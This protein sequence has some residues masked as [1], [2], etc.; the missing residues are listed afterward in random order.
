MKQPKR[1]RGNG[2]FAEF[3][4][5]GGYLVLIRFICEKST[6]SDIE[7]SRQGCSYHDT[8]RCV[9]VGGQGP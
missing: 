1:Q 5:P 4:F 9:R 7:A 2:R 6:I 8:W 3:S